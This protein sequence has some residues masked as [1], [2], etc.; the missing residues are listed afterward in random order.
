[1]SD[2]TDAKEK[3]LEKELEQTAEKDPRINKYRE[4]LTESPKIQETILSHNVALLCVDMQH[5]DA[6]EGYGVL[7][8]ADRESVEY[9][10]DRLKRVVIPNIEKLQGIFRQYKLEVLH[11][12]IQSLTQDGRDRSAGHKRLGIH[13]PPD[14]KSAEFLK[15]VAPIDDEIVFN[16]TSSGVF[17]STNIDYVLRNLGIESLFLCGVHTNECVSTAV[18]NACDEGY[19]VTLVADACAAVTPEQHFSALQAIRDRY[20]RIQSTEE[21][22]AEITGQIRR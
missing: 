10:F 4:S 2:R 11:T 1:M 15:E 21:A 7:K 20:A 16:K 8:D 6:A 9:Y 18:R 17:T 22:I 12:R 13:A 5:F 3:E 19:Y 14:S